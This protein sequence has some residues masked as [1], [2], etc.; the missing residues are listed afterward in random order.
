M[1]RY[2]SPFDWSRCY[3]IHD[4]IATNVPRWGSLGEFGVY[5]YAR[6]LLVEISSILR[7]RPLTLFYHALETT[8][9]SPVGTRITASVREPTGNIVTIVDR[10]ENAPFS[11]R[12]DYWHI[13]ING[14]IPDDGIAAHPPSPPWLA[15]LVWRTIHPEGASGRRP[16]PPGGVRDQGGEIT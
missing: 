16:S 12:G 3:V 13:V 6:G 5:D 8:N 11:P 15:N 10:R 7:A 1:K 4:N 9:G 14:T 2:F